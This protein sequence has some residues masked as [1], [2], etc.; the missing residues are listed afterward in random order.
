MWF[1]VGLYMNPRGHELDLLEQMPFLQARRMPYLFERTGELA[2][3][4]SA[5]LPGALP[6]A[7]RG[8]G[9]LQ[10]RAAIAGR[11]GT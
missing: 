5:P 9:S 10:A 2:V 4:S 8:L 3:A 7:L 11:P 6:V 1:S